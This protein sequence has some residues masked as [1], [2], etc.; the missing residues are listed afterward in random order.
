MEASVRGAVAGGGF[1]TVGGGVEGARESAETS[2]RLRDM[3]EAEELRQK[4][5]EKYGGQQELPFAAPV[6]EDQSR[7]ERQE[8]LEVM[9]GQAAAQQAREDT[10]AV[11]EAEQITPIVSKAAALETAR[12][13]NLDVPKT[14]TIKGLNKEQEEIVEQVRREETERIL[15]EDA[16]AES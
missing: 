3:K 6:T 8:S 5:E 14:G 13:R 9:R 4:T 12:R 16:I 7:Q 15:Y 11:Q 10:L 1:G 2:S